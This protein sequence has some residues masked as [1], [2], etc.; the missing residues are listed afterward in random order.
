VTGS[1]N[2]ELVR[3]IFAAWERGEFGSV[4]WAHPD[5]EFVRADGPAPGSWTGFAEIAP[6]MREVMSAWSEFRLEAEKYLELDQQRVLVFVRMSGRG[7]RSGLEAG[8]LRSRSAQLFHVRG[9]RVTRLVT[10]Y[11]REL[12]LAELAPDPEAV[13]PAYAELRVGC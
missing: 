6:A 10:Y 7:K 3:S 11:D 8:Q 9:G 2:L 1:A 13:P 12:A 5:V 4:E